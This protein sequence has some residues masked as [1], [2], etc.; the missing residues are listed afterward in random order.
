MSCA[1][2]AVALPAAAWAQVRS[3][4]ELKGLGLD[5]LLATRIVSLSRTLEDWQTAPAAIGVLTGPEI[6]RSG[7]VRLADALRLAPGLSVSRY[8][9]SS[10]SI[11]ARGFG[12]A[13]VNKLQV[14]MDGRSLYTPLFSGVFWEVQD[15]VLADLDR[16]EVVRGPGGTFWGANAMNGVINVVSKDARD[17]QGALVVLGGGEQ[18]EAFASVRYGGRAGAN[19]WYRAYVKQ[20]VRAEQ[21]FSDG[22]GAADGMRQ[23]QAGFRYDA[24][25]RGGDHLTVQGDTYWNSFGSAGRPDTDSQG[26]N[27]LGRWTRRLADGSEWTTQAYFDHAWRD[28]P[29]QFS[30]RRD[31]VDLETQWHARLAARHDVVAGLGYRDS[32]DRTG[33]EPERTFVFSPE[34]RRLRLWSGFVQDEI[35]LEPRRWTLYAG[36]KFEHN[37]FTGFEVQPSLRLAFTPAPEQTLWAAVSRA[38]RAPTRVDT[39]SRFMPAP[40]LVLIQGNPDFDSETLL[41]GELGYRVQPHHAVSIDLA[42]F[43]GDYRH[44][45]TLEPTPPVGLPLLLGNERNG[46]TWG[47]ELAVTAQPANSWRLRASLNYLHENLRLEPGSRDTTGATLEA[48]DPEWTGSVQS[49]LNLAGGFQFD[50][51]VR[52]ASARPIA[53]LPGYVAVDVRLAWLSRRDWELA[54]IGQ[55]IFDRS[56]AE[57]PAGGQQPEVQRAWFVRSMFRF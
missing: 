36:T 1:I 33:T 23:T 30:E 56:H 9:G 24:G 22:S 14:L 20:V 51:F 50:C 21:V 6:E 2:W 8:Y 26:W 19:G 28:V 35:A 40:G 42:T 15:T 52:G 27:L 49:T 12:T 32:W 11:A 44:L 55:N 48:D 5:E 10:Y 45:R 3:P 57:F 43:V 16:I 29:R 46:R 17:T 39:D 38:V 7:A 25:A 13:S 18:E 47:A 37:D 4:A 34:R 31:T 53:T 54:L 41:T